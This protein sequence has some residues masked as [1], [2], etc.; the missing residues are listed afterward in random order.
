MILVQVGKYSDEACHG[1]YVGDITGAHRPLC[2]FI[3]LQHY[4]GKAQTKACIAKDKE[5]EN[6]KYTARFSFLARPWKGIVGCTRI[7]WRWQYLG[8]EEGKNKNGIER[9]CSK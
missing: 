6:Q 9:A 3:W 1:I 5:G 7:L 8:Q 4:S 2:F